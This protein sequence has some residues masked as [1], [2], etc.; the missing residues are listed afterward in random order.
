MNGRSQIQSQRTPMLPHAL[1]GTEVAGLCG[2][3]LAEVERTS[4]GRLSPLPRPLPLEMQIQG[5]GM[6]KER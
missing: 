4:L 5:G 3:E 2:V 1:Q 6:I